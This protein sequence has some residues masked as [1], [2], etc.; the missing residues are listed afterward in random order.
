MFSTEEDFLKIG[1][2]TDARESSSL[3]EWVFKMVKERAGAGKADGVVTP[4]N[5][6]GR[7]IF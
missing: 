2:D 3:T 5:H 6:A 1:A 4:S 7:P